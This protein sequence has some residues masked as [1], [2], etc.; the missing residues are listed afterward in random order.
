MSESRI[1]N[2][3]IALHSPHSQVTGAGGHIHNHASPGED[4]VFAELRKVL[5]GV[6]DPARREEIGKDIELMAKQ[7][8]G[9]AGLK[10]A[11]KNFMSHASNHVTVF[12]A[13]LGTL[14][15]LM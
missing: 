4:P 13:L 2:G 3:G 14:T 7:Q 11:Y 1:Y 8:P 10:E 6:S 5:D 9:S 15:Q 12:S